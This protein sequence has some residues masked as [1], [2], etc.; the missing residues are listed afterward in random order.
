VT[1]VPKETC[2]LKPFQICTNETVN[3]P[4]L[5]LVN[6]CQDIPKEICS[7]EKVKPKQVLLYSQHFLFETYE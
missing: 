6:E 7:L 4:S 5:E 2:S 1:K 3:L